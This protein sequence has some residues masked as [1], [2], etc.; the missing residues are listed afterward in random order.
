MVEEHYKDKLSIE[1]FAKSIGLSQP[2]LSRIC[3]QYL[4]VSP[5]KFIKQRRMLEAKRLLQYTRLSI[6]EVSNKIGF[7][8]PGYFCRS[9]KSEVKLTP[10]EYRQSTSS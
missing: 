7:E 4:K 8:D 5:H 3:R 6:N 9:F 2:H 10:L 1:H